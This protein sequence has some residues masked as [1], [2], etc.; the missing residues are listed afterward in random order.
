[1]I[2]IR[3]AKQSNIIIDKFCTAKDFFIMATQVDSDMEM[4]EK[5]P[6]CLS[7]STP[8]D[9][10]NDF[11]VDIDVVDGLYLEQAIYMNNKKAE[12]FAYFWMNLY[13]DCVVTFNRIREELRL[14]DAEV[15]SEEV[16]VSIDEIVKNAPCCPHPPALPQLLYYPQPKSVAT[17]RK[18]ASIHDILLNMKASYKH[19]DQMPS[20]MVPEPQRKHLK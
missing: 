8:E 17:K 4:G 12:E 16:L 2:V 3:T 11:D 19:H 10:D 15:N 5:T 1:M 14:R 18:A 13:S 9:E 20:S 7:V 6:E